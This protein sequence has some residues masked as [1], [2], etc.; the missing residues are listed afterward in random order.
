MD[1]KHKFKAKGIII[2][3]EHVK[4]VSEII[5]IDKAVSEHLEKLS[6]GNEF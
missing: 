1:E 3:Y 2:D 4:S 5:I 6:P